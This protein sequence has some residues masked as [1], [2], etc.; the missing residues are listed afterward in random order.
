MPTDIVN[1]TPWSALAGGALIGLAAT[2]FL[3]ANGRIAGI[4]GVLH[5][6]VRQAEGR[7]W[8]LLFMAGLLAGTGLYVALFPGDLEPREGYPMWLLI[9][10]GLLVGAGTRWGAGCTSGHGVC[11]IARWSRRS[12]AATVAFMVIGVVSASWL[13]H[14]LGV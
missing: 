8:R 5:G 12:I 2:L 6:A 3:L 9:V 1:F 11:G 7:G 14:L 13:R 10:A 4:S